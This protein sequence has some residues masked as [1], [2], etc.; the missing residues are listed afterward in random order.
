MANYDSLGYA[1][2]MRV[3]QSGLFENLDERERA[4][5]DE[6]LRRGMGRESSSQPDHTDHPLRHWDRTCPACVAEGQNN[7]AGQPAETGGSDLGGPPL[8]ELALAAP[9]WRPQ[10]CICGAVGTLPNC[11][12]HA[13]GEKNDESNL[14]ALLRRAIDEGVIDRMKPQPSAMPRTVMR[15]DEDGNALVFYNDYIEL[16]RELAEEKGRHQRSDERWMV[17][18]AAYER[19]LSEAIDRER[20]ANMRADQAEEAREAALVV[21]GRETLSAA[22]WK[23]KA[24]YYEQ[25]FI[26]LDVHMRNCPQSATENSDTAKDAERYRWLHNGD[27]DGLLIMRGHVDDADDIANLI[28]GEALDEAVD[29]AI[30][31]AADNRVEQEGKDG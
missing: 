13:P 8:T 11:P 21:A 26:A 22:Y 19:K 17:L 5:C 15:Y 30:A 9:S 16:K 27:V 3:L 25:S 2:A 10:Q 7:A 4:E 23:D 14:G 31:R 20:L 24:A 12:I 18:G 28:D 1:L 29:E 6:L